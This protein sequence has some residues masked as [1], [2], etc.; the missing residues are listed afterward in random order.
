[1]NTNQK[2]T[3]L[4]IQEATIKDISTLA[5]HH[6]K[7]FSEIWEMKGENYDIEKATGTW[8]GA[9]GQDRT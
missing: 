2:H 5:T 4:K 8:P 7:M 1:M 9:S 6:C 3:D